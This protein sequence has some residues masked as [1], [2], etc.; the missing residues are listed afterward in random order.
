MDERPANWYPQP[1]GRLRYWDGQQ[2]T[3]HV[4][5]VPTA[6][7]A[8][9]TWAADPG[10]APGSFA[11]GSTAPGS[12][13]FGQ[14]PAGLDP[15]AP[16]AQPPT[17][18]FGGYAA[19]PPG[20]G[21]PAGPAGPGV[22]PTGG[23]W[24]GRPAVLVP[25]VLVVLL[26]LGGIGALFVR[27]RS[28]TPGS[29][30]AAAPTTSPTSQSTSSS[31]G[32]STSGSTSTE[33]T[34]P[35]G[36]SGG[37]ATDEPGT[38]DRAAYDQEFGTFAAQTQSGTGNGTVKL[39]PRAAG[40]VIAT[41]AGDDDFTIES[42]DA[43]NAPTGETPLDWYGTYSGT[44]AFGLYGKAQPVTLKI[45]ASGA[46]TV[47]LAP[48]SSAPAL[49]GAARGTQDTVY[50]YDGPAATWNVTYIGDGYFGVEQLGRNFSNLAVN[51]TG[52]YGGTISLREGPSLVMIHGE[53]PW[54][55]ERH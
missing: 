26:V 32:K 36:G 7:P 6:P 20:P 15:W 45:T 16:P 21:G 31:P 8:P 13:A 30:A 41:Y 29:A 5:E 33:T 14:G 2:W 1:D 17:G 4:A 23:S 46:W 40:L 43:A 55:L 18:Q 52:A 49:G 3:E 19:G 11:P 44:T 37:S 27:S 10:P 42:L 48:I 12:S 34:A 22:R 24:L 28:D 39:P 47:R 35:G 51:E 53:G 25:A 50:L 9:P 54:H 38:A